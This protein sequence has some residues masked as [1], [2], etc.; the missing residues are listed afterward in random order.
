M[1]F[2][3]SLAFSVI[4][5]MLEIWSLAP[6][7]FLNPACTLKVL[8]SCTTK[9]SLKDF[10]HNLARMWNGLNCMV[11]WTFFGIG[12]KID[13]FQS[14]GHC[15]VFQICQHNECCTLT[16]LYFKILYS[17][18]G[19]PSPPVHL[20]I[21]MLSYVHLTSYST[22]SGSRW[23]STPLWLYKSLRPYLYS[24]RLYFE[25][26][27]NHCRWWLEPWNFFFFLNLCLMAVFF[28]LI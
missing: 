7:P 13:L 6:L 27:Q 21:V 3:N 2:W 15:W 19:I 24:D 11:I 17:L 10:E 4:Q 5:R 12:M 14:C 23:V 25:G 20:F 1:L 26:L 9:P 22:M 28:F 8:N 18:A 16:A